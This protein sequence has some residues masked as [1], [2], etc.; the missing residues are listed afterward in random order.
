MLNAKSAE[1]QA[2]LSCFKNDKGFQWVVGVGLFSLRAG[3]GAFARFLGQ[4][5]SKTPTGF[6]LGGG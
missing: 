5:E 1:K 4:S 3:N 2:F 6:T